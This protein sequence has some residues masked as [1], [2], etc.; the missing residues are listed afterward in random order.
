MR[1]WLLDVYRARQGIEPCT[2]AKRQLA[3]Q[4]SKTGEG[5]SEV[6]AGALRGAEVE[7]AGRAT[8][9]GRSEYRS[10]AGGIIYGDCTRG[11]D[12]LRRRP[13]SRGRILGFP[14]TPWDPPESTTS[15]LLSPLSSHPGT[16]APRQHSKKWDFSFSHRSF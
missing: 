16:R 15:F 9:C 2:W 5:H 13:Q 8:C 6:V 4:A 3:G 12:G 1:V 14:T 11:A 10:I 7:S